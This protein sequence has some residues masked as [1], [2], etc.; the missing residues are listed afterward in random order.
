MKEITRQIINWFQYNA[1]ELPWR[2]TRNPYNIWLSEIILQQTRVQQGSA[3]YH[4][5][6]EQYPQLQ[7]LASASEEEVLGLW[8]GLGYYSRGRNLLKTAKIISEKYQGRFPQSSHELEKLPGIGPYTS[9]AIAS[10]AYGEKV[11]AVDGNVIRVICRLFALEEDIRQPSLQ[12]KVG[13]IAAELLPE[14][15]SWAFNQA[16]ME[17]GAMLCTPANPE[18]HNCPLSQQCESRRKGIQAK[19]PF[20]SKAAP[21]KIRFFN[22][23]L[24][25]CEGFYALRCREGKDIWQGLFEPVLFEGSKQFAVLP[26]FAT[27]FPE[28]LQKA[29]SSRMLA[30]EK[31]LLSHQEIRVSVLHCC[32]HQ[33]PELPGFRWVSMAGWKELPKPVIFSKILPERAS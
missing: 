25:E 13:E 24:A 29:V 32:F 7:D 21:R 10:F 14:G 11:A 26:E 8:Q 31:C 30:P 18:C 19:L 20:K 9:A 2:Q 27:A 23:I 33:R 17:F 5:F 28:L 6:L 3:Y 15:D 12:K 16:M 4:R 22:Y 1:R